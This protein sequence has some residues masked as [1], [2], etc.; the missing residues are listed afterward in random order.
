MRSTVVPAQITTVEDKIAGSL[1][2]SQ[3]ILLTVPIFGGSALYVLLPPFFNYAVYKIV[4]ITCFT[5]LCA[6]LAIRIKGKILLFWLIALLR[7][8]LRPRY[9]L[10]NKND[11][12]LRDTAPVVKEQ[13]E[14]EESKPKKVT[15]PHLPQLS[16]AELVRIEDVIANPQ[17]NLHFKTN[18][19]GELYVH[20]TEVR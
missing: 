11:T 19:K 7:Y 13:V 8:N 18:R 20:I 14:V 9:Y 15:R 12:H 4:F 5:A 2:L 6:L 10:F 17:A 1:G 16:T 3:L